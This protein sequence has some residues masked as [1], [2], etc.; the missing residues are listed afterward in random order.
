MSRGREGLPVTGP[1]RQ[2]PDHDARAWRRSI[3][4]LVC[5][6]VAG[7]A[8]HPL[9][10]GSVWWFAIAGVVLVVLAT[11]AITRELNRRA[12]RPRSWRATLAA[13]LALAGVLTLFIAQ[14]TAFLFVIPTPATATVAAELWQEGL[15]SIA[16]QSVPAEATAGVV[17]VLCVGVGVLAIVADLLAVTW[18]RPALA[19][20]T[21]VAVVGIPSVVDAELSDVFFIL[22]T[23]ACWL[24]LLRAGDPFPQTARSLGLG[25]LVVV[26]AVLAPVVLPQVDGSRAGAERFGGYLASVN[27]VLELGEELRRTSPREILSYRPESGDRSYLRLVSLRNFLPE[28]WEPDASAIDLDNDPAKVGAPTGLAE[29]VAVTQET[30]RVSVGNLGSP[31]L[32]VPYP[33]TRVDGLRGDWYWNAEDLSFSSPDQVAKGEEYAVS[34]LQVQPA[35]AQLEAAGVG[36]AESLGDEGASYLALPS[37]L[38]AIIGDTA[39][40]VTAAATSDYAKA[41]ALQ[42]FFRDGAFDYSETAPVDNDYDSSGMIAIA[43]FLEAK[44]GYCIHFASAMAIMARTL[45][46]PSR[47]TVGFLPGQQQKSNQDAEGASEG[48]GTGFRVT[49][50][51]VHSWPELYFE[52]VGWTRFEPTPGLGFVPSYADEATPGVPVTPSADRPPA[53]TP[54]P[55]AT[56]SRADDRQD[57]LDELA[58]PGSSAGTLGALPVALVALALVL[59]LL[60]PAFV[61]AAQRAIRLRRAAR[62][63][64]LAT[65]VWR[66]LLQSANDLGIVIDDTSTPREAASLIAEASRLEEPE[67]ESLAWLCERVERQS[68]A[69]EEPGA[70]GAERTRGLLH[71]LRSAATLRVRLTA[72]V[73]PPTIWF[74][75]QGRGK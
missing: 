28:T 35:P 25:A 58:G 40:E 68:F 41:V 37:D 52:G 21:L 45:D 63:H 53:A 13:V 9:L 56:P 67:R 11:A 32:P 47:V 46:I 54:T 70:L 17:F 5:L 26:A 69:G 3:A 20:L 65:T 4:L 2:R 64:P 23:G 15:A 59:L 31:W 66:E 73:A 55:T 75:I 33:A 44:S 48:E 50:R 62:G 14:G 60:V 42:E 16:G 61:R 22:L 51:D 71:R 34:S 49:T 7:G 39:R 12:R 38:P 57:Q 74:W 29:G 18:R 1:P 43:R 72:L 6:W 8:L 30:T 10:Q 24:V 19:G 27:P 36:G